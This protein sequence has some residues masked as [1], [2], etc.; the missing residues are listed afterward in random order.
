MKRYPKYPNINI[1]RIKIGNISNNISIFRTKYLVKLKSN[2]KIMAKIIFD[3]YNI[4][5][6][7]I[8][9]HTINF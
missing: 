5:N 9:I 1:N 8:Y 2:F 7:K 6:L 4:I 3:Y